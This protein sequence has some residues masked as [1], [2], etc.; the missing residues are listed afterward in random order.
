MA[1]RLTAIIARWNARELGKFGNELNLRPKA[2]RNI[3]LH[4]GSD[5]FC[6]LRDIGDTECACH[7]RPGSENVDRDRQSGG[8]AIIE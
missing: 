2:F 8:A 6:V 1:G 3:R 7:P 5:A 4:H